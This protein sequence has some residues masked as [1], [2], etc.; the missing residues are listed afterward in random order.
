MKE[1]HLTS[2]DSDENT[3]ILVCKIQ[4]AEYYKQVQKTDGEKTRPLSSVAT[5]YGERILLTLFSLDQ[6]TQFSITP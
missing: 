5:V 3:H 1:R 6:V 2:S 4:C